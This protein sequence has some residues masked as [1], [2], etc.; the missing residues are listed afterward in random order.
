M[1]G[2]LGM[3]RSTGKKSN[4]GIYYA[5]DYKVKYKISDRITY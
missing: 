1:N 3:A 4:Y 5:N 2:T